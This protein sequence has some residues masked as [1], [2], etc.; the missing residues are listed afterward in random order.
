MRDKTLY[1]LYWIG[2]STEYYIY[3]TPQQAPP[4]WDYDSR[5]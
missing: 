4:K 2:G 1:A 5:H 3:Y